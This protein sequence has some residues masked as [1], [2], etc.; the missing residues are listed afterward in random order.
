MILQRS[1]RV[2]LARRGI[3]QAEVARQLGFFA[4]P[5]AWVTLDGPCTPG[6][7]ITQ[8]GVGD[9]ARFTRAFEAARL[10]GRCGKFVPASGAANRMF[11]ALISARD[12]VNPM[13]RD[14][15]VLAA[16]AGDADARQALVFG[17]NVQR[18]AF[19]PSLASAM[20]DAGLDATTLAASGSYTQLVE[21]L[22]DGIG[23]GYAARPKGLLDFHVTAG[24]S[25]TPLEEHLIEAAA[26][27]GDAT[28]LCRVHITVS[29]DHLAQFEA[30]V[31]EARQ[32][33]E[34]RLGIRFEVSLSVQATSS[35]TVAA[36]LDNTPLRDAQGRLVFRPGGHGALLDNLNNL[37]GDVVFV[38]NVDNVAPE[39]L[40]G[41]TV[42]WKRVLGGCLVTVQQEVRRHMKALHRGDGEAAVVAALAFLH[43]TCGEEPPPVLAGGSWTARR[44]FAVEHLDRPLRVCGMVP[45]QGEPGGGPFWVRGARGERLRQIV[46]TVQIDAGAREQM[47]MLAAATHFNPVDLVCGLRNWR[48]EPFD[49]RR[50]ADPNSVF[51]SKKSYAGRPVKAL[52]HPGLWNGGMARWLSLFIEVP[53]ETFNPV[54]T[55]NDLLGPQ[56]RPGAG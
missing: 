40:N 8:I 42:Q 37:N 45:N 28:G 25:R 43:D 2:D 24:E 10:V 13:T 56:H 47:D 32:N 15:L 26:Y 33:H 35:D 39:Q 44:D 31:E 17:E 4:R 7:G 11:T 50:F 52:E 29:V 21:Y 22:V 1:D 53:P 55:V 49:L 19:F 51:I 30:A 36:D 12:R 20:A 6:D 34:D 23:L 54:K 46:E 18:F 48:D 9:A 38:K 41:P 14:A 5:P 27:I 16:E 3:G